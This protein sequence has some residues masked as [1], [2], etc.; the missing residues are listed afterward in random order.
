MQLQELNSGLIYT[1]SEC[2]GCNKCISGCVAI[3]ANVVVRV[4]ES[5]SYKVK[6]DP[7]KCILCG[8]CIKECVHNA[9]TYRDDTDNFFD[10][11]KRG[12]KVSVI[13]SPS[14]LTDYEHSYNNIL[15]YLKH[16]GVNHIYNASFGADIMTWAYMRLIYQFGLSGVISQSCPVIVNYLEKYKPE[17]LEYLMPVQSPVICTAIY[18]SDYLKVTDK[19]AY[20][21]P[22]I[23][24][25]H[26]IDDVNTYGKV[27]YNVTFDRLKERIGHTDLSMYYADDEVK[28]GL[29][30]LIS[31]VGGLSENIGLY[32]GLDEVMIQTTGYRNI[33]P[34]F[35]D[36]SREI[37]K[38]GELPFLVEAL[39]CVDGC[40]FGTATSCGVELRN[41]VDFSAHRSRKKAYESGYVPSGIDYEERLNAMNGW[42]SDFAISSFVRQ[43]D[44]TRKIEPEVLSAETTEAIYQSMY[45]DTEK[46]RHTDCGACGYTTCSKMVYAIGTNVNHKENCINY[47]KECIQIETE[48]TNRLL[49]AISSMNDELKES[50]QLKTNFLANMSH[51]IRT[52]MNA[53][54]G[55]AEM[56]LRGELPDAE[57][58]YIHQIKASGRSLLAIINDILDFSKIESGKMEIIETEYAVM[59]L[60]N[61]TVNIV[62]TRI[63]EKDITLIVNADP[64]IPF[65]LYG[66]DIRIKQILVNLT[67]NAIKFTKSGYVE[68]SM[69]Y[70]RHGDEIDLTIAVKDSGIGIKKGDIEKLFNTFQQVDSKRN[71]NIEG[72]GLGLAISRELVDL[73]GGSIEVE[74]EYGKGSIF[75]FTIPQ[76]IM[77]DVPSVVIKEPRTII[78]ASFIANRYVRDGYENAIKPFH[79]IDI[80]CSSDEEM[81]E[82]AEAGAE[83]FFVEYVY[84]DN[85]FFN[86]K[87]I[88][89]HDIVVIVDPRKDI[90]ISHHVRK[91]NQPVYS[92]SIASILNNE[93]MTSYEMDNTDNAGFEAPEAYIL[94]VDDNAINLTVAEGLLAPFHMQITSASSG[95]E[96]LEYIE[97]NHYDI[98]FMDHMMPDMDGVEATHMIRNK[99][100]GYYKNLPIIALTANAINSAKDLFL[101]EGMNDFV[102]KPIEMVDITAK[103]RKWLPDAKI[104]KIAPIDKQLSTRTDKQ[105]LVIEGIDSAAGMVF[106]GTEE[107]YRALLNDYYRAIEKK[108]DILERYAAEDRVELYT[109]EVHALKSASKL[110]GAL[111]LSDM[112]ACLEKCGIEKDRE[113]IKAGTAELL[114]KYRSYLPILAPFGKKEEL[115]REGEIPLTEQMDQLALLYEALDDFDIDTA[116][117]VIG[118]IKRFSL[119]QQAAE[120]RRCLIEAVDEMKYDDACAIIKEW[121]EYTGEISR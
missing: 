78:M 26:E 100:G 82:A 107:L 10:A 43:Y 5:D 30:A 94:I 49:K 47:S 20:I 7:N 87:E 116:V 117:V 92:L 8:H 23:A 48:K 19:L 105:P 85:E 114:I 56:A 1:N 98:V 58:G 18:V 36:Y 29:G 12:E 32:V 6:V 16:I 33:F 35:E 61:D 88:D 80:K 42:F 14:L 97:Q 112:A 84:W 62:M 38:N 54:I 86:P 37:R 45:K 28:Y 9:R 22:C 102:A 11:L 75:R 3:G 95:R 77:E 71:R 55:M 76:R 79:I 50:A 51:E 15:G 90:L 115:E 89:G 101:R 93:E 70:Q 67:N 72:T 31:K 24:K 108:A 13:V 83:Y 103:L 60:I 111:E 96:A 104:K 53:V 25:K 91:I 119:D 39:N 66:D 41:E 21:S 109:V 74:S 99:E 68:I 34:Y 121:E 59:S 27:C 65:K 44:L 118:Q 110:I 63:D 46:K 52:P 17:L 4:K 57:R 40:N 2:I 73:M 69:G 106:A 64:M 81:R 113:T 120:L